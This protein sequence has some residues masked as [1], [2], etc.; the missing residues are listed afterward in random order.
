MS[1]GKRA[2]VGRI[3]VVED[4]EA[5]IEAFRDL[6]E[7]EGYVVLVARDGVEALAVLRSEPISVLV[8]DLALPV[9]DGRELRRRQL[10]DPAIAHVPA[11]VVTADP[12]ATVEGTPLL[13]K[14]FDADAFLDEIRGLQA[15]GETVRATMG[16]K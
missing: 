7:D 11:L 5:M 13:R 16:R 1:S 4:H 2:V 6:L 9:M 3:L 15:T 12:R 14:P 8:L 10:A